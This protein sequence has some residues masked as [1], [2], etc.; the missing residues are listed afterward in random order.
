MIFLRFFP[1]SRETRPTSS[2]HAPYVQSVSP[3]SP[4]IPIGSAYFPP[5]L[6]AKPGAAPPGPATV[7]QHKGYR[8]LS[9]VRPA[10]PLTLHVNQLR[11][12]IPGGL[13][14]AS[15]APQEPF[16]AGVRVGCLERILRPYRAVSGLFGAGEHVAIVVHSFASRPSCARDAEGSNGLSGSCS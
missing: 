5:F 11:A 9:N 1:V 10:P 4:A 16:R 2:G 15:E 6:P 12:C 7:I 14:R 8:K 3:L 13:Y